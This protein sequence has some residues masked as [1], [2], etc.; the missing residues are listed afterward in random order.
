MTGPAGDI[1]AREGDTRRIS[2]ALLTGNSEAVIGSMLAG[3]AAQRRAPYEVIVHDGASSD[4]TLDIVRS[5]DSILNLQVIR[6]DR[7]RTTG[8]S[9]QRCVERATGDL[10]AHA[11]H[12]DVFLPDHFAVLSSL[13]EG[14]GTIAY[15]SAFIWEPGRSVRLD[16]DAWGAE[17][18]PIERQL[19]TLAVRN[20]VFGSAMYTR[21]D[22][23]RIARPS[24][25]N[26]GED[27][28]QWLRMALGGVRFA[29]SDVPTV[30]YRW[31]EQNLS[32]K[33][34]EMRA[35]TESML[36]EYDPRIREQIGER[37]FRRVRRARAHRHAW[38]DTY[39]LLREGRDTE[40]RRHAL[41]HLG[42]R[43][44]RVVAAAVL[45]SG[46]LRRVVRIPDHASP[47]ANGPAGD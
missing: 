35:S 5:Y 14:P 22:C 38:T 45:P 25:K 16:R 15:P 34:A 18:P 42:A 26:L 32:K 29:R 4:S 43:D 27:W 12:D 1:P 44:R 36:A 8:E 24:A 11:D 20:F 17:H 7:V 28:D 30:L 46:V 21:D 19:E 10:I 23:E 33:A 47:A 41:R 39:A 6:S 31:W 3:L 13:I 9:R 2:V 37:A 40:A